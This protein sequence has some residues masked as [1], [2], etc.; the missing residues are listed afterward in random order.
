MLQ[1][2]RSDLQSKLIT[3]IAFVSYGAT[4][5]HALFAINQHPF[6]VFVRAKPGKILASRQPESQA[7]HVFSLFSKPHECLAD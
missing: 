2:A 7:A 6:L 4:T 3:Y 1:Y 5:S